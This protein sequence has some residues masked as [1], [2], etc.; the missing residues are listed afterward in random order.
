MAALRRE[1]DSATF[2][3]R[4]ISFPD[5][6]EFIGLPAVRAMEQRYVVQDSP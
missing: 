6:N 3:D 4:L 2:A 5:F 1:G